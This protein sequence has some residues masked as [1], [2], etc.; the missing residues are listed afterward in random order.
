MTTRALAEAKGG[1]REIFNFFLNIF[2]P[3]LSAR[4]PEDKKRENS[5]VERV[6]KSQKAREWQKYL[7]QGIFFWRK[8]RGVVRPFCQPQVLSSPNP[9]CSRGP[10]SVVGVIYFL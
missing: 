10:L 4:S 6:Q 7:Q 2:R 1:C 9:D 8:K 5:K 3:Q